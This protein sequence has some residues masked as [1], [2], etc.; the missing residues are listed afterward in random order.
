MAY[1]AKDPKFEVFHTFEEAMKG[2]H[3]VVRVGGYEID[4]AK[5]AFVKECMAKGM[6]MDSKVLREEFGIG[7][8][9][10]VLLDAM[11]KRLLKG[12]TNVQPMLHWR[13][14]CSLVRGVSDF[15]SQ[16]A[17][18]LGEFTTLPVVPEGGAYHEQKPSDYKQSY[19][20][21]KYGMTFSITMEA[22]ANDDLGVFGAIPEKIGAAAA[23]T[24]EAYI[25]T[26]LININA[27]TGDSTALF[28]AT[29]AND[30]GATKPLNH[31]NLEA[32]IKL[33]LDQTD[34]ESNPLDIQPRYLLVHPDQ[35]YE[36]LRL[37]K[38]ME[39]PETANRDINV[40]QGELEVLSSQRVTTG[41][42]YVIADPATIDTI[43]VGFLN[44][45]EA[46][47]IFEEAPN[48]GHFFAYD[49]KR[50]KG[51]LIFGAAL[52]DHRGFVRANV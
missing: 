29:H 36:A 30:L 6:K 47:E 23:R 48:T 9:D 22:L 12:W 15:R 34:S 32:A 37:V 11:H 25:L 42:W 2:D 20:V 3:P 21:V 39:R 5:V 49:E 26:S 46:P 13:K 7:A 35:K 16:Y 8:W 28:A 43:E 40:H 24:I 44:G 14:L 17:F 41:R 19:A 52:L 18:R 4:K 33:M 50:Y 10:N 51:R 31:D 45:L 1:E 27:N 38:G